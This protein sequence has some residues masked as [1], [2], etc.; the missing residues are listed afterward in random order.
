MYWVLVVACWAAGRRD[1]RSC[2]YPRNQ[3]SVR[4]SELTVTE[5]AQLYEKSPG[6]TLKQHAFS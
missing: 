6:K 5:Q 4:Q 1:Y 2:G 3:L